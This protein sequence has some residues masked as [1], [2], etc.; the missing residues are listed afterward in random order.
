MPDVVAIAGKPG[1]RPSHPFFPA[2]TAAAVLVNMRRIMPPKSEPIPL[3]TDVPVSPALQEIFSA[4]KNQA[5]ELQQ[6]QVEPLH[7]LAALL[8]HSSEESSQALKQVG[9][10]KEAV[11]AALRRQ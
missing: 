7:L 10:S 2:E 8:S 5:N 11:I 4:A 3:S 1:L 6:K 9:I